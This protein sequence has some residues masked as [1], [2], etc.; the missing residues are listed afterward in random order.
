MLQQT[1]EGASGY[2]QP[3]EAAWSLPNV[4]SNCSIKYELIYLMA[5]L[6]PSPNTL[7]NLWAIAVCH[8]LLQQL[9]SAH[10][11]HSSFSSTVCSETLPERVLLNQL[12]LQ[13]STLRQLDGVLEGR[14]FSPETWSWGISRDVLGDAGRGGFVSRAAAPLSPS[15]WCSGEARREGCR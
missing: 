12:L 6:T 1:S 4:S 14:A 5:E 8:Q 3:L 2:F 15:L 11:N 7:H 10:K 13:S 9:L